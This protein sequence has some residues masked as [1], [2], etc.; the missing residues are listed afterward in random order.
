MLGARSGC[1]LLLEGLKRK[2]RVMSSTSALFLN[3]LCG[4]SVKTD[5][6]I[7]L[8]SLVISYSFYNHY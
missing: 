8:M 2:A 6:W 7:F 5:L 3:K 4:I 1:G